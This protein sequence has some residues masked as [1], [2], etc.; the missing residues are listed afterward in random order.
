[1]SLRFSSENDIRGWLDQ[2]NNKFKEHFKENNISISFTDKEG[3]KKDFFHIVRAGGM[4][5][6]RDCIYSAIRVGKTHQYSFTIDTMPS[7]CGIAVLQ[8]VQLTR[9]EFG[10]E[11]NRPQGTCKL[12]LDFAINLCQG[13]GYSHIYSSVAGNISYPPEK[14]DEIKVESGPRWNNLKFHQNLTSAGFNKTAEFINKRTA[15]IIHTFYTNI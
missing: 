12:I 1:M 14:I 5:P 3:A 11:L 8:Y 9:I 10:A 6:W 4:I 13:L 15:N 7:C 2:W